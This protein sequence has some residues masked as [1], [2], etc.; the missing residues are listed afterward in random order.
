VSSI[1][2]RRRAALL[3]R[4]GPHGAA[5]CS[6]PPRARGGRETRFRQD[7]DL[8]YLTGFLE[9]D[10]VA[11]VTASHAEHRFIMFVPPR[12]PKIETWTGPRTGVEGAMERYEADAAYS[13]LEL[14]QHL[15]DYLAN[16]HD[17]HYALGRDPD[18]DRRV[19]AAIDALGRKERERIFRPARICHPRLALHELRLRKDDSEIATLR[20]SVAATA[21][22]HAAAAS[23]AHAG[24]RE[25]ELRAEL[26]RAFLVRGGVPGYPSIIAAGANATILHYEGDDGTLTAGELVL[27]DAGAEV[28]GYVCDVSRTYPVDGRFSDAQRRLYDAVLEAQ[29]AVITAVRPGTPFHELQAITI[30][31]L[32]RHLVTLGLLSGDPAT[33]VHEKQYERFY[34]HGTSHWLGLDTHDVGTT[35]MNGAPRPLEPGMVLT[36]EPGLYIPRD[37]DIDPRYGGIGIRIEDDLLVTESGAE[38]LTHAIPKT[39]DEVERMVRGR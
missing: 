29:T 14:D 2:A 39:A 8:R 18:L 7:S 38:V 27:I 34:M 30:E 33:L 13:I 37:P 4:L 23:R 26:E 28:D 31:V 11:L 25:H 19:F 16:V 36:V 3:E 24:A 6:S 10:A 1:H 22:G 21:D 20:R 35:L 5:L 12:D 32:T 17:L 15:P 9:P